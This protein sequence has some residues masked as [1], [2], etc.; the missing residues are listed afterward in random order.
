MIRQFW[1]IIIGRPIKVDSLLKSV[2]C[3]SAFDPVGE[4]TSY[5]EQFPERPSIHHQ[6]VNP[7]NGALAHFDVAPKLLSK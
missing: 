6:A 5:P 2:L 7:T 1:R 4:I 3:N